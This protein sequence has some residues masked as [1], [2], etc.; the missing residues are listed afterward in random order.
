MAKRDET[1]RNCRQIF[2][3]R[4]NTRHPKRLPFLLKCGH[5]LCGVCISAAARKSKDV[6]TCTDCGSKTPYNSSE[7]TEEQLVPNIHV[8]GL[9]AARHLNLKCTPR[10]SVWG[11]SLWEN[12]PKDGGFELTDF[13]PDGGETT[14]CDECTSKPAEKKCIQCDGFFCDTCFKIVHATANTLRRHRAIPAYQAAVPPPTCSVHFSRLS[15]Y[16][17]TD[18]VAV[19]PDC[20]I[21]SHREHDV[22]A[23]E[24]AAGTFRKEFQELIAEAQ[25]VLSAIKA[26]KQEV[27]ARLKEMHK[28]SQA[29]CHSME[30]Q[31]RELYTLLQKREMALHLQLDQDAELEAATFLEM[32]VALD[33]D[34]GRVMEVLLQAR[35]KM[36]S[37]VTLLQSTVQL[38]E[39]LQAVKEIVVP[40]VKQI[41][42]GNVFCRSCAA[43]GSSLLR[44][45]I[46][47][48]RPRCLRTRIKIFP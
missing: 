37:D 25:S 33:A 36:K 2:L 44:V 14:T 22:V 1:C 6:I 47:F 35:D 9:V 38:R 42:Y 45:K 4:E 29:A 16:C 31:M 39:S 46:S 27:K 8:L 28:S 48:S 20:I 26:K 7:S 5:T 34:M 21:H 17:Q 40:S 19:C 23:L 15:Y 32:E 41:R 30:Q 3:L 10:K 11:R 12:K 18:R 43:K 13:Q 24:D